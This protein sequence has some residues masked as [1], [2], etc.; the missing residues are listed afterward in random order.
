MGIRGGYGNQVLD[1]STSNIVY[2]D[3]TDNPLPYYEES[4]VIIMPS[5]SESWGRVALEAMAAGIPVIV[6]DTPGLRECTN[7]AAPVCA[8]ADLG[9]WQREI[10]RLYADGPER[11]DAV[12]KG[13]KRIAELKAANDYSAFDRF[14]QEKVVPL[15]KGPPQTA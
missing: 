8:Q 13:Y 15:K 11:Q 2:K 1:G 7:N 9:C 14:I 6:G 4:R 5:K 10:T 3:H 12:R